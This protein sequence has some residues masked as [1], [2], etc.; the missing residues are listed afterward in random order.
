MHDVVSKSAVWIHIGL[1]DMPLRIEKAREAYHLLKLSLHE[2]TEHVSQI[3][4][5]GHPGETRAVEIKNRSK[6]L[7]SEYAN[8]GHGISHIPFKN[9][10]LLNWLFSNKR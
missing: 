10:E 2:G 6:Y 1:K 7:I 8:D 9:P 3:H 5:E 4:I